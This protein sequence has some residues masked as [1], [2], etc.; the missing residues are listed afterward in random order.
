M[1]G[2]GVVGIVEMIATATDGGTVMKLL[3]KVMGLLKGRGGQISQG[4]DKA[5][6]GA[7]KLTKGKYSDKIDKASG[8]AK[9]AAEKLG[10]S[11]QSGP[12]VDLTKT[13]TPQ[14][15]PSSPAS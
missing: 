11:D 7:D 6:Q 5:A 12:A 4:I 9:G 10:G 13:D 14:S 2:A 15:T 8:A 3:D 1:S